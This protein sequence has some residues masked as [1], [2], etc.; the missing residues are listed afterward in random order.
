MKNFD[1]VICE[2]SLTSISVFSIN[3]NLNKNMF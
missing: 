1:D 2:Y 3:V